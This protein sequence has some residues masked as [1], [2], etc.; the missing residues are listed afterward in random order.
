[1]ARKRNTTRGYSVWKVKSGRDKGKFKAQVFLGTEDGKQKKRQFTAAREWEV[2]E[3]A[4]AFLEQLERGRGSAEDTGITF[5]QW[6]DDWMELYKIPSRGNQKGVIKQSTWDNYKIN[7]EEHIMP[8]IGHIKL[9]ELSTSDIQRVY[10]AM[11]DQ[12]LASATIGKVHTIINGCL[13]KAVEI[14]S[15]LAN[16]AKA[17]ERPKV[18]HKDICPLDDDDLERF[19]QKLSKKDI[20]WR[21]AM[22]TLIGTGLRAGE[23]L[24]L[25]W[26]HVDLE[27]NEIRVEKGM[28]RIKGGF[29]ITDPKT[30]DSARTVPMP[31]T[32]ANALKELQTSQKLMHLDASKNIVFRTSNNTHTQ[33][34]Q[35]LRMFH[36]IRKKANIP[37][38]TPH[39]LRH[40]FATRLLE[41][42]ENLKVVQELLGHA[43]IA[44]TANIYTHVSEKVK[45]EAV[46]KLD[47]LLM[48]VE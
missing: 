40:T 15:I 32:V 43:D 37:E 18:K 8:V 36:S 12:G 41:E 2:R 46:D 13:N 14:G 33:Y 25:E 16:P 23:L 24:A 47:S 6:I 48:P 9:A 34:R 31:Q 45:R 5:G 42:G 11:V 38:A 22:L 26:Q 7:I 35:L 4:E 28:S 39:S 3:K 44:T 1:M 21:A 10:A 17:T 19:L 20:R 29:E 30:F 27:N